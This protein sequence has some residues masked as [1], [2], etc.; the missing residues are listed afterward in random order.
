MGTACGRKR[1][2]WALFGKEPPFIFRTCFR[3]A[4][5]SNPKYNTTLL[6][7][8][9]ARN[10]VKR[11]S[12]PRCLS[13]E[14]CCCGASCASS[15]DWPG[16]DVVSRV[17]VGVKAREH[18]NVFRSCT[19]LPINH[20]RNMLLFDMRVLFRESGSENDINQAAFGR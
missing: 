9:N 15:I 4:A 7:A 17:R 13:S 8:R 12:F 19:S 5:S 1:C 16:F 14:I 11:V 18:R 6:A 10:H 3:I 20:R 2:T